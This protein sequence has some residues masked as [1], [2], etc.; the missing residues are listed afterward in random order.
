M[1][2]P[3]RARE[4]RFFKLPCLPKP[5]KHMYACSGVG[6]GPADL[7]SGKPYFTCKQTCQHLFMAL[8]PGIAEGFE[9]Q[10]V[11]GN[12]QQ[13]TGNSHRQA[14]KI[15]PAKS[16]RK[17]SRKVWILPKIGLLFV[18]GFP[19]PRVEQSNLVDS[20]SATFRVTTV[21]PCTNAV[22]AWPRQSVN[23]FFAPLLAAI[24]LWGNASAMSVND[25]DILR[26]EMR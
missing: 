9:W 20:K 10:Q 16:L 23:R 8:P 18:F 19:R 6:A 11:T 21:I 26:I 15:P 12:R 2:K 14:I 17:P 13:V 22:E 24:G 4:P 7:A 5:G 1:V 25:F 3:P